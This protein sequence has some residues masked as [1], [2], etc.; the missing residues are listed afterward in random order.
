MGGQRGRVG[1]DS[2]S[3]E[4]ANTCEQRRQRAVQRV[5][6]VAEAVEVQA[7]PAAEGDLA[8]LR[9]EG[10]LGEGR[11]ATARAVFRTTSKPELTNFARGHE[12]VDL[13]EHHVEEVAAAAAPATITSTG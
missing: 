6:D 10:T 9:P 13:S 4:G 8:Q 12:A 7:L 11:A 3:T 1:D 2:S 5:A